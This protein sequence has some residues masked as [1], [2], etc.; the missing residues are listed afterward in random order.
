MASLGVHHL[1]PEWNSFQ[2]ESLE[3]TV[4]VFEFDALKSSHPVSVQIGNPNQIS[5]IFDRISYDKGVIN[6]FNILYFMKIWK[7]LKAKIFLFSQQ[8]FV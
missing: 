1:H 7:I 8:L 3:N 2:E 6:S 4:S 5:A